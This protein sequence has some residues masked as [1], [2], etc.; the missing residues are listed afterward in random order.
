VSSLYNPAHRPAQQPFY[1]ALAA[2][3]IL[4]V[5]ILFA[6]E[7]APKPPPPPKRPAATRI[8]ATL[9]RPTLKAVPQDA[10]PAVPPAVPSRPA[11]PPPPA[12]TKPARP[13]T[14]V[15]PSP[16][17]SPAPSTPS[18]PPTP[19]A[20][21]WSAA[22]K[23]D[24][25][26]FLRE[27]DDNAKNKPATTATQASVATAG[28]AGK[29]TTKPEDDTGELLTR[30]PNT[31][32]VD[33][34]SLQMYLDGLVKKLNRSSAFVKNDP[35]SK[36]VKV[37]AVLIRINPNG[38]L[39]NFQVLN[40]GDQHDEIAFIQSVVERAVPFPAFSPDMKVS[41][42]ELKM[43]ICIVPAHLS[44]GGGFGFSRSAD[45]RRC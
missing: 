18:A 31:P 14:K 34:F 1:L 44:D 41:A 6:P 2:S 36:G 43:L 45:G 16:A 32:P 42:S 33:P 19:P 37:A 3:L 24:M 30:I 7:F 29:K 25:N 40:T 35:R 27:L 39:R 26:K 13:D 22:E 20:P 15:S 12:I 38:S 9:A 28:Q 4:H 23:D 5:A 10:P 11:A 17:I 21:K 8:E